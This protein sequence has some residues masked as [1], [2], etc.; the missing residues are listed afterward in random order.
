[1]GRE[2]GPAPFCRQIA[3]SEIFF[4]VL[5]LNAAKKNCGNTIAQKKFAALALVYRKKNLRKLV[6]KS[7]IILSVWVLLKIQRKHDYLKKKKKL[8][9]NK[10][11]GKNRVTNCHCGP[12]F[13]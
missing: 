7:Q 2:G 9:V 13:F 5:G 11:I 12:N 8:D 10:K 4:A 3:K 6:L 1:M